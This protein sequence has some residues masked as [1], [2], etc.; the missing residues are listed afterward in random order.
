MEAIPFFFTL[1]LLGRGKSLP[2]TRSGG[3][4][5]AHAIFP[6]E[7]SESPIRL[8]VNLLTIVH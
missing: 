8:L 6:A 3:E 4:G 5:T 2:R 1:A 7:D